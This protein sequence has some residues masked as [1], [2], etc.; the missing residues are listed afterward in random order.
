MLSIML[1][2]PAM[3]IAASVLAAAVLSTGQFSTG[4]FQEVALSSLRD[5]SSGLMVEGSVY[6]RTDGTSITQLLI[7]VTTLPG[8]LPVDID[9]AAVT[10]RTVVS[11][12]DAANLKLDVPYTV[13]WIVGNGDTQLE[14]GEHAEIVVDMDGITQE[15]STFTVEVRPAHG[16]RATVR[17]PVPTG[18]HLPT[19]LELG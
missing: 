6:A 13:T 14:D 3:A 11:Y 8:G 1:V 18:G 4:R 10:D 16:M 19:I 9:P 12:A 15:G 5:N 2:V 17:R 7:D